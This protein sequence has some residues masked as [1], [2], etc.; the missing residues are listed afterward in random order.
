[1]QVDVK[2]RVCGHV[3]CSVLT[4]LCFIAVQLDLLHQLSFCVFEFGDCDVYVPARVDFRPVS[5]VGHLLRPR[6]SPLSIEGGEM[7]P[8]IE[9]DFIPAIGDT[10]LQSHHL[11]TSRLSERVGIDRR[12]L[13]LLRTRDS[14]P[15]RLLDRVA[16]GRYDIRSR[17]ASNTDQLFQGTISVR[18]GF[19]ILFRPPEFRDDR[20]SNTSS[21]FETISI[22]RPIAQ[23]SHVVPG[24][25]SKP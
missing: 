14:F 22:P 25:I 16:V 8:E 21:A 18:F 5:L 6:H 11:A 17:R 15:Q 13:H 9:R 24:L 1:M 20:F 3:T 7:I 4:I 23:G 12:R 10:V 2:A 19:L